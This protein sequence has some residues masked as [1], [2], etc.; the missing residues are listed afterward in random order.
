MTNQAAFTIVA[1]VALL[2]FATLV[3]LGRL[4]IPPDLFRDGLLALGTFFTGL[5]IKRPD[6]IRKLLGLPVGGENA[7]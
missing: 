1:C 7:E 3:G 5:M 2:S 4:V 6:S